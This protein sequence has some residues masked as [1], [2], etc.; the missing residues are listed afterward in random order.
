MTNRVAVDKPLTVQ[1][2]NGPEFTIIQGHQV[3]G[4]TNGDG[5]VRCVYLADGA[6][7]SGFTLTNGAT[8][9]V[10]DYPLDRESSG[11]GVW[12]ESANALI[13]NCIIAGNSAN[14]CGGGACLCTLNN[15]TLMGNSAGERGG[16]AYS[17]TLDNCTL[18]GN[19]AVW[20]GGAAG[21]TLNN[22]V[23]T[24]NSSGWGGGVSGGYSIG[25][26]TLN[27]CLLTGNSAGDGG[28]SYFGTLYNCVLTG[29]SAG[30]CGGGAFG[31]TLNNCTLT[32]N[33][34]TWGGGAYAATLNNCTLISNSASYGG[35][36]C[37]GTL[38]N[39][40]LVGNY[41]AEYGG[42]AHDATLNNCVAY[43][44]SAS[45]GPNYYGVSYS[46]ISLTFC[47]TTPLPTNGVGNITN[48]PLFVDTNGWSN[49]R[50]QSNSSCI[51]AGYNAYVTSSTDLDGN[52]RI[53]GGTVDIGA[54]EYQGSGSVIS[55]A[56]LQQFGLPTDG[57]ADYLDTDDDS[58]NNWQ[59]WR[60]QTNPTN[61]LSVLRLL[62]ASSD[63]AD[64]T[65]TWQSVAGVTYFL[66]RS[67]N[68]SD[69]PPFTLLSPPLPGQPGTTT[70]T[71]TN[72]ASLAPLFYRM[73]VAN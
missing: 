31:G 41:A 60:C 35:G 59:E 67:T 1:S 12:C 14:L 11:G 52:P 27:N 3:P 25:V 45:T 20:G 56:W 55:Y 16:G 4:T 64:V 70:Y 28:G 5:A 69:N 6:S 43:Y 61:A 7:L 58:H 51:N 36:A 19:S 24:D 8:R 38:N 10:D 34:V 17:S 47:C 46:P 71:D 68:L 37:G 21:G 30:D 15:C 40:T 26:C 44:N 73:G 72:A 33:S 23:L 49:L 66:E 18:S 65:V 50:L 39:C 2:V 53:I 42:G 48:A 54:Y 32:D 9:T 22:C 62:P 57:S 63:G 13:S 29:N